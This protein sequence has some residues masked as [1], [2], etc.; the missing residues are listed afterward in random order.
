MLRTDH[1][2]LQ[3]LM[4]FQDPEG[5]AARLIQQLQEYD[6]VHDV[7]MTQTK[8]CSHFTTQNTKPISQERGT[9]NEP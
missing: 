3:W 5:Q 6:Y 1:S 9:K 7:L 4:N 8:Q 2:A